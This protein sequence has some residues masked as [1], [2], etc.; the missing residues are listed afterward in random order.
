MKPANYTHFETNQSPFA[1]NKLKHTG[2]L[3]SG[4]L[5]A[6]AGMVTAL[7]SVSNAATITQTV[8][9]T[10]NSDWN[11]H[12]LWGSPAA[13]PT[14]GNNYLTANLGGA[15]SS[16]GLGSSVTTRVRDTGV[17]PF[18]GDSL[19][20]SSS[21]EL[22]LKNN[23]T[24]TTGNVILNGGTVRF[25]PSGGTLATLAGT[26]NVAAD[27]YLGLAGS[28][29]QTFTVNSA[30][31]GSGVLHL[32]AGNTASTVQPILTLALGGDLSGFNGVLNLGGGTST[33]GSINA[34]LDFNLNYTLPFVAFV[35]GQSASADVVNLDQNVTF[36]SFTF[37]S[38][39]L[40]AGTYTATDLNGLV[41]NGSQFI[42]GGGT[43]TVVPEPSTF[44]MLT[45]GL[46]LLAIRRRRI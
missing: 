7:T 38:T 25:A 40:A 30:I 14:A 24:T 22:L 11:T 2:F 6:I 15:A 34:T 36:G 16:T 32:A 10:V 5:A 13:V 19:T 1:A 41:G 37:G 28:V 17:N 26:L 4:I 27:S 43:L 9:D 44:A 21:T 39:S 23:N 20:I 45:A 8:N 29:N 33:S 46:T 35:M 31:T 42:D 12:A 3:R 18:A